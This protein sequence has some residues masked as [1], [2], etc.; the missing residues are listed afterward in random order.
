[1]PYLRQPSFL[2]LLSEYERQRLGQICP[3]R[4]LELG[5][6]L[7]RQGDPCHSLII[8]IEGQV[9]LLKIAGRGQER[10]V[11]VAGGGD[12]LGINFLSQDAEHTTTAIC[13]SRA[14]I[15]PVEKSQVM[16]VFKELPNVALRLAQVLADRVT[17]LEGQLEVSS[18]PAAY[19]LGRAFLWLAQRFSVP[20]FSPWR[21]LPMELR[22]EDLAAMCGTTRVTVT[23]TLGELRNLGLVEGTR[24]RYRV[25]LKALEYWLEGFGEVG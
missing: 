17:Q 22:Q 5:E 21:D 10:I 6:L 24:G 4:A 8:L 12:L 20:D 19:R 2:E 11:Y 14:V 25:N 15:C 9:K 7:Y 16:Q 1:M 3:P 18:A 23:N 13:L